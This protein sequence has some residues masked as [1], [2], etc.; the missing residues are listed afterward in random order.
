MFCIHCGASN[1]KDAKLCVN[2][3]ESLS[4]IQR[5]ENLSSA[6]GLNKRLFLKKIDFLQ[7]LLDLSF[8]QFVS[9]Q[10]I[11]FLYGLSILSAGLIALFFIII[12]FKV[13]LLF[14]IFALFIGAPLLFLSTVIYSRV[15]LD[16]ILAV[17][18]IA[19]SMAQIEMPKI[20]ERSE[21]DGI[22]W[23]I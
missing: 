6:R 9:P 4:E 12:G 10:T 23:N 14:G 15:L 19:D 11:K 17:F 18:R 20:E 13:S 2:C 1:R 21:S 5:V 3:N 16:L 7:G 8:N 22:Q